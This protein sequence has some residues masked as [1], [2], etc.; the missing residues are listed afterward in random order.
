MA[1]SGWYQKEESSGRPCTRSFPARI[2]SGHGHVPITT[3]DD[4]SQGGQG[5]TD[6]ASGSILRR[7]KTEREAEPGH[8]MPLHQPRQVVFAACKNK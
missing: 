3:R 2:R 4:R 8:I 6:E 1:G 5:D 7:I